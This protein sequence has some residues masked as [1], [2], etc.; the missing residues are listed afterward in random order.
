MYREQKVKFS[1]KNF[2]RLSKRGYLVFP[3][4]GHIQRAVL[5]HQV[6]GFTPFATAGV[7]VL[8]H[9]DMSKECTH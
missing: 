4:E 6:G 8:F 2:G 1:G 3:K 7:R 5:V 9:A